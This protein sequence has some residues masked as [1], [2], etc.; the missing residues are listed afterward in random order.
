[1]IPPPAQRV[2][3]A[4]NPHSKFYQA[5]MAGPSLAVLYQM[6]FVVVNTAAPKVIFA[7]KTG[8]ATL[9]QFGKG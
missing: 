4:V 2:E 8:Y 3:L 7:E 1:M 5:I 9:T 6:L